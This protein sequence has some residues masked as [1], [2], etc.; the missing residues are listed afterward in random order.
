MAYKYSFGLIF[1]HPFGLPL[2]AG[3]LKHMLMSKI[4]FLAVLLLSLKSQSAETA[5]SWEFLA[6]EGRYEDAYTLLKT[7]GEKNSFYV[8]V[9]AFHAAR[10][11]DAL[12]PLTQALKQNKEMTDYVH[13]YRGRTYLARKEYQKAADDFKKAE[14]ASRTGH[15]KDLNMFYQAEALLQLKQ[16]K[17]AQ[18]LYKKVQ[19]KLS[20]TEYYPDVLWGQIVAEVN[21]GGGS[22]VC[23]KAKEI[24]IK[25]PSYSKIIDWGIQLNQ[26]AVNGKKLNCLVT[27]AE[28]KLRLQ[29]LSW[30]G[31][32][33][34]SLEEITFLQKKTSPSNEFD[35]DELMVNYLLQEG[36]VDQAQKILAKYATKKKEDYDY[37]MLLGKVYSRSTEPQ[38]GVEAYYQAYQLNS[39]PNL[40][41]PAL[42]QSA[43]LSYFSQ[44]YVGALAKFNEYVQKFP[45]NK[46]V[47]DVLWYSAWI[48][49]LQKNYKVAEESFANILTLKEKKPRQWTEHKEDKIRYWQA[50]SIYRQGD[51]ERAL[52]QMTE[53]THDDSI[54]YYAVAAYQRI[55]QMSQRGVASLKGESSA[56]HENWWMPEALAKHD[57]KSSED[58][59][60]SPAEDHFEDQVDALLSAEGQAD[61]ALSMD[62]K[63]DPKHSQ[64]PDD[65]RSVYFT[66]L[67]KTV[68]RSYHL[69]RLGEDS[70]AYR[71]ILETEGQKLTRSQKEWLLQAHQSV[72]SFNRSVVLADHFFADEG[73]KLGLTHGAI[74]WKNIYP[75]AFEN[76][77]S[78]Y[79][80]RT[81]VPQ[82]FIWSIMRAETIYRPD[83]VSPVGARGLMQIMPKT[84]RKIASLAGEDI[85]VESLVRPYV[86]IKLGS[87]Y[88]Q[89]VL[90]KFNN[91]LAL[92]AAAYNGGPHRVHAWMNLFGRLDL[93]E[94]IE[95]IPY[96][97]TRNY[98]KKVAKYYASYNL[99]YNQNSEAMKALTKPLGFQLEGSVPT[100][101]T[102]EKY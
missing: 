27:F 71:E 40:A 55:Q 91:N 25:Y 4:F 83:A 50:M 32:S 10:W 75:K 54:G 61:E 84:G 88:L 58:D 72:R 34:K 69:V 2:K 51:A 15:L 53:L 38:K 87:Y 18:A 29:R 66:S 90:K 9:M 92:A 5:A 41:S 63:I 20:R 94:F 86:S 28:Q 80:K 89:R 62:L 57:K 64:L 43:F 3:K 48:Q 35:V 14:A 98:V 19:K 59:D 7:Q 22:K 16:W 96:Q 21:D 101:E 23:R 76:V 95:H 17:K 45:Q 78:L 79:S 30:S 60:L 26:N 46:T 36:Y 52:R 85:E 24:Y 99:I 81:K 82:E 12:E 39:K 37:L 1:F 31:L 67:E 73:R 6:S 68:Q 44:D 47:S 97:E 77:V 102:W 93:D 56:I 74:Y 49:Y 42:F 100:M 70:L 13:M 8:G 33:E 65:L 11:D